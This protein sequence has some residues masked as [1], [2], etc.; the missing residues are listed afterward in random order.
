MPRTVTGAKDRQDTRR[1]PNCNMAMKLMGNPPRALVHL[2][3]IVGTLIIGWLDYLTGYEVSFFGFYFLSV[4]TA[5]W[6]AGR[7]AGIWVAVFAAAIWLAVDSLSGHIYSWWAIPL[8]NAGMRLFTFVIIA[9]GLAW[10]RQEL[11]HARHHV[12][13]LKGLLPICSYCKNPATQGLLGKIEQYIK[14]HSA[15]E[16]TRHLSGMLA[17]QAS[18]LVG[19]VS[20]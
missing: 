16:F 6:F 8:W 4:G 5:A 9:L 13:E 15:A 20:K 7:T 11:D 10:I 18:L 17:E 14:G 2:G 19:N 3:G 1:K 12:H